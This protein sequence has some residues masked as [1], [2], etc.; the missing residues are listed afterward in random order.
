MTVINKLN[1]TMALLKSA[2]S[3]FLTFSLDTQDPNAKQMYTQIADSLNQSINTFQSRINFVM[4]EEPSYQSSKPK[5]P[6]QDL[7]NN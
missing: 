7:E 6:V 3:N 2:E 1:Q 5:T 4:S